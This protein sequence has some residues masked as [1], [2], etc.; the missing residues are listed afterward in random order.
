MVSKHALLKSAEVEVCPSRLLG[1]QLAAVSFH[2]V[3][4]LSVT[5]GRG[6]VSPHRLVAAVAILAQV[7]LRKL[8]SGEEEVDYRER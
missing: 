7:C 6:G 3:F 1:F 8:H 2:I 4:V 5:M